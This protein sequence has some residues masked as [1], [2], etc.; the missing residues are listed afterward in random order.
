MRKKNPWKV[1]DIRDV[2]E[3]SSSADEFEL[4][5]NI[6]GMDLHDPQV[7]SKLKQAL[8]LYDGSMYSNI[9]F[10]DYVSHLSGF[11][12]FVDII[13]HKDWLDSILTKGNG[14]ICA[15]IIKIIIERQLCNNE[16]QLQKVIAA[17][18]AKHWNTERR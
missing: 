6:K 3:S 10:S 1:A 9:T 13:L 4:K 18:V 15:E 2:W 8:Q 11:A 16:D 12:K 5:C 14:S 17:L 7:I